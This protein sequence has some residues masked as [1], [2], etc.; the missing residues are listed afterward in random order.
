MSPVTGLS[1]AIFLTMSTMSVKKLDLLGFFGLLHY[2]F[3]SSCE[4]VSRCYI[5]NKLE[6]LLTSELPRHA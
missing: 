2:Q 5:S 1:D 6:L 4:P 3:N